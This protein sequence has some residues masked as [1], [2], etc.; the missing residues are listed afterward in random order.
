MRRDGGE[1]QENDTIKTINSS[2]VT[3]TIIGRCP[4]SYWGPTHCW[5]MVMLCQGL[6]LL[7]S[8]SLPSPTMSL[9]LFAVRP[10]SSLREYKLMLLSVMNW[11]SV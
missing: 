9:Y 10:T 1:C 11:V 7:L 4:R 3:D 8:L 5:P 6:V 2:L